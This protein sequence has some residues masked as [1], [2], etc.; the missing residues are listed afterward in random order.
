MPTNMLDYILET[1]R[2]HWTDLDL[3]TLG[4]KHSNSELRV[5]GDWQLARAV[6]AAGRAISIPPQP[7]TYWRGQLLS[8]WLEKDHFINRNN[9]NN[10]EYRCCL[11]FEEPLKHQPSESSEDEAPLRTTNR[12]LSSLLSKK[13][14]SKSPQKQGMANT[15]RKQ[16]DKEVIKLKIE[17]DEGIRKGKVTQVQVDNTEKKLP[18]Q[19]TTK[20]SSGTIPG[21][22]IVFNEVREEISVPVQTTFLPCYIVDGYTTRLRLAF[23]IYAVVPYTNKVFV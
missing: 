15:P 12:S 7:Q 23:L 18:K 16:V 3:L 11:L 10:T 19:R 8:A 5:M 1:V 17:K 20:N 2:C 6:D 14:A 13:I 22:H 21:R 4:P 9:R